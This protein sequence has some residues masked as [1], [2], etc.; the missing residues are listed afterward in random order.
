MELCL[1]LLLSIMLQ[2]DV[3]KKFLAQIKSKIEGAKILFTNDKR[4]KVI[5]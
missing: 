3:H 4:G 5:L 1:E 2:F